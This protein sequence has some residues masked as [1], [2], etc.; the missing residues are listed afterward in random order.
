MMSIL[1]LTLLSG[2]HG[3]PG[4]RGCP[5]CPSRTS[6]SSPCRT[7]RR[8]GIGE[9]AGTV[10][11]R[12]RLE[13][14]YEDCLLE[15]RVRQRRLG[16]GV[17]T[18]DVVEVRPVSLRAHANARIGR[19]RTRIGDV[20]VELHAVGVVVNGLGARDVEEPESDRHDERQQQCPP[21]PRAACRP[22]NSFSH[23]IPPTSWAVRGDSP[24]SE[25]GADSPLGGRRRPPHVREVACSG[26]GRTPSGG[27]RNRLRR[28][29]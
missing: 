23:S 14:A 21:S 24:S 11:A 2:L 19:R 7:L 28:S 6:S 10:L 15:A 29:P 26:A 17:T 22:E 25:A 5:C 9:R 4:C 16:R 27:C 18:A 20:A 12:G 13:V 1:L 8:P 3:H